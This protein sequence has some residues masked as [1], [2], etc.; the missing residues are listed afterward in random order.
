MDR[1]SPAH[2]RIYEH[3]VSEIQQG[4]FP[5]GEKMPTEAKIADQFGVSRATVQFAM[6]RL[7]W[8]GWIK[9]YPGRGTYATKPEGQDDVGID[10]HSVRPSGDD[11]FEDE[12]TVSYQLMSF[13]RK[14]ASAGVSRHLGIEQGMP[15]LVLERLRFMGEQPVEAESYFFAPDIH[16]RFDTAALDRVPTEKL[17][18]EENLGIK[19]DRIETTIQPVGDEIVEAQ[20]LG[21]DSDNSL[22]MLSQKH[23]SMADKMIVYCDRV[24]IPPVGFCYTTQASS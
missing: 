10:M 7:A 23:F 14:N 3:F 16:P 18:V 15:V 13:G 24:C 6:S 20:L 1:P 17:L 4:R 19:I 21:I 11:S 22:L 8:N 12:D 9:R 5:P 2:S